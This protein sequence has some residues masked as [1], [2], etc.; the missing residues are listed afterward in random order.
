MLWVTNP[1]SYAYWIIGW[2]Q[3]S[4][5][6]IIA[7]H[8]AAIAIAQ[9]HCRIQLLIAQGPDSS[10]QHGHAKHAALPFALTSKCR[11]VAMSVLSSLSQSCNGMASLAVQDY[12]AQLCICMELA[13]KLTYRSMKAVFCFFKAYEGACN[14]AI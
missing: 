5:P 3:C 2:Q 9:D 8:H 7:W 12:L 13:W 10:S 4:M 6:R 1:A 11:A 14:A